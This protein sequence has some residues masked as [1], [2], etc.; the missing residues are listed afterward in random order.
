MGSLQRN[1]SLAA[2]AAS[3]MAAI[4][5]RHVTTNDLTGKREYGALNGMYDTGGLNAPNGGRNRPGKT[6][7]ADQRRIQKSRNQRRARV[8]R[9]RAKGR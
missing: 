2:L 1:I 3:A 6:V 8:Q 9:S 4:A 5:G 7:R